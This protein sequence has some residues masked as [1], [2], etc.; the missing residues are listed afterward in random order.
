MKNK[1][2]IGLICGFLAGIIDLIPMIIQK[3]PWNAN[4]SALTMWVVIGFFI[5]TSQLNLNAI[6]K[7]ILIAF[8]CFIPNSF[9]I[10]WN[11]PISLLPIS[12]MTIILGGLTGYFYQKMSDL[13]MNKKWCIDHLYI[14]NVV[15]MYL[16]I[17]QVYWWAEKIN[18][19][20]LTSRQSRKPGQLVK[21]VDWI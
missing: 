3:L 6:L 17:I 4:L 16:W 21:K 5:G 8:L 9:I 14:N 20:H 12:L 7:G 15:T 13:V 2:I 18:F 1:L 10:G 11:D 19:P